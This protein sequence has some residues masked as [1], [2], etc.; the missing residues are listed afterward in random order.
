MTCGPLTEI[1]ELTEENGVEKKTRQ[2]PLGC[3]NPGRAACFTG[4]PALSEGLVRDHT[5]HNRER[6]MGFLLRLFGGK[7]AWIS[8]AC[9]LFLSLSG[10]AYTQDR[11]LDCANI[12]RVGVGAG[13]GVPRV[14]AKATDYCHLGLGGGA[15]ETVAGWRGHTKPM[16]WFD[17]GSAVPFSWYWSDMPLTINARMSPA[18]RAYMNSSAASAYGLV[19]AP[20]SWEEGVERSWVFITTVDGRPVWEVR[21]WHE[22]LDVEAYVSAGFVSLR[23]GFN[24]ARLVNFFAGFLDIDLVGDRH[25]AREPRSRETATDPAECPVRGARQT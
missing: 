7:D 20:D 13:Y 11:L 14:E 18:L 21:A 12:W 22:Q 17:S 25:A 5:R 3:Y 2:V 10:C 6:T 23:V 4:R 24:P 19:F 8:V 16:V 15:N 1:A 9:L